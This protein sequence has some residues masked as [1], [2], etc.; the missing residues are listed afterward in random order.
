MF[1]G[2]VSAI[3]RVAAGPGALPGKLLLAHPEGW[4]AGP[5]GDSVAVSGCCLTVIDAGTEW[6]AVEVVPET[7][8]RTTLGALCIDDPVNLEA[9][10][11]LQAAVGGHLVSGHVD[12]TGEIVAVSAEANAAWVEIKVP[13]SVARYCVPQGSIAVD[14]CSFT[15]ATVSDAPAGCAV[16]GVSVIPH[17]LASTI[18]SRYRPHALVNLEA[19]Q[20]AKL[21]ERFATPHRGR[22]G[23]GHARGHPEV[24]GHAPDQR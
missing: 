12:A 20:I 19:D 17:T 22:Y 8:R 10:L 13:A 1:A 14:G 7:L 5:I 6:I 23:Q 4:F 16:I 18:A 3:G 11:S 15:L 24:T 21:V 2:I 9:S